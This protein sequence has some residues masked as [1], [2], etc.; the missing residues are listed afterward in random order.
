MSLSFCVAGWTR[1]KIKLG[2]GQLEECVRIFRTG[3]LDGM[4]ELDEQMKDRTVEFEGGQ[5]GKKVTAG[6]IQV[7]NGGLRI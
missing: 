3:A 1:L 2:R 7:E 5:R 4:K 6:L